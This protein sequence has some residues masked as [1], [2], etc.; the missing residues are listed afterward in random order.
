MGVVSL[1]FRGIYMQR[2]ISELLIFTKC[3]ILET[4]IFVILNGNLTAFSNEGQIAFIVWTYKNNF[5]VTPFSHNMPF[6][7]LFVKLANSKKAE[8]ESDACD[9]YNQIIIQ[10]TWHTGLIYEIILSSPAS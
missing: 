5:A 7:K 3:R 1:I 9:Y 2:K 4:N 8:N 6:I 10:S